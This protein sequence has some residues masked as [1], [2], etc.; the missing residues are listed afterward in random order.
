MESGTFPALSSGL[1]MDP[2][3]L[4]F[5]PPST[6]IALPASS[7]RIPADGSFADSLAI[8]RKDV[9][10]TF[11]AQSPFPAI[12][13]G[14]PSSSLSLAPQPL[15]PRL[16]ETRPGGQYLPA[17]PLVERDKL[18][19]AASVV[20]RLYDTAAQASQA[21]TERATAALLPS[22]SMSAGAVET[23]MAMY[24]EDQLLAY[25]GGD[26][27]FL[28]RSSGVYAPG[29][30]RGQFENRVGKDLADVGE[31]LQ[32]MIKDLFGGTAY[33]YV[34][35]DG[36]IT[37]GQRVGLMQTVAHFFDD[38][39]SGLTF[40]AYTPAGE[41]APEGLQESVVHFFKKIFYDGLVKDLMVG[42]P[43]SAINIGKDSAMAVIN[44]LQVVPDSIIGN[45]EWGQKLT[46]A[47]FD[48]AQVAVAYL[49]DI[50]PSGNAWLRVHAMGNPG[51]Q[52]L[53]VLYNLHTAETGV[54]DQRWAAVRN[55]PF[56]KTI[57]TI[58]SLLGDAALGLA[59]SG[60]LPDI[61][62]ERRQ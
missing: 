55:T 17:P 57:E 16:N 22:A 31:N 36:A 42:V 41:K 62:A 28:D 39:L 30:D 48:N 1:F 46:T 7:P 26:Y 32:N 33:K 14:F 37:E 49:T 44:L 29:F 24:K 11:E 56:R 19:M 2:V 6:A 47:V 51:N 58:G 10:P 20:T 13:G 35:A 8:A 9:A 52:E 59:L 12:A 27:Y 15:G 60:Q 3:T 23:Q 5:E 43:H 34:G 45:F 50:I 38:V 25:P 21:R 18:P 53:P 4:I 54:D 61:S 40:G